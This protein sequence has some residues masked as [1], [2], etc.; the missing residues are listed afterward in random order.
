MIPRKI[1]I[2]ATGLCLLVL[3]TAC[4]SKEQKPAKETTDQK[5]DSSIEIIA[6]R[7]ASHT[8]PENT[9]A[10]VELAW[11]KGADIVEIDVYL[12]ADDRVMALHDKTTGRTGDVDLKIK[13]STSEE[14]RKVD[15]GS[16][17]GEK[18]KGEKIPF[19]KEIIASVP[20][21]KRLFIEIKDTSEIIPFIKKAIEE[22]GKQDQMIIIGFDLET[23]TNSKKVMPDVPVYW[24]QST[25]FETD[26]IQTAKENGLDG[27]DVRH[28]GLTKEFVDACRKAGM[29]L[30]VWTVNEKDAIKKM[31]QMGVDGIT[32]DRVD[33]TKAVLEQ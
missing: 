27:V 28:T 19:L 6:H 4:S 10:S 18:Y 5:A 33:L 3:M 8:A 24:V 7:G 23:V 16:F 30:Y 15:V 22:S 2:A 26:I 11:E 20:E 31:A 21:G 9:M 25:P 17:K 14:L 32:T 1:I 12:T 29:G 13:E